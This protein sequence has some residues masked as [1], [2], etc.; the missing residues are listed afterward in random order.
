MSK[1]N[2]FKTGSEIQNYG[3]ITELIINLINCSNEFSEN[4]IIINTLHHL[5]GCSLEVSKIY[6]EHMVYDVLDKMQKHN[7]LTYT[8]GIFIKKSTSYSLEDYYNHKHAE[9]IIL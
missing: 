5:K 8:N 1:L 6:I 7:F 2:K 3:E 4:Y 9:S